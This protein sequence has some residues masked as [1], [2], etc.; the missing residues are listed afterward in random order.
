[1][2]QFLLLS[3]AIIANVL[4]NIGFK[5]SAIYEADPAK[6]WGYLAVGLVFGLINS[7]LFTESLKYFSLQVASTAFFALTI[8]GLFLVSHYWF[9][10]A[11]TWLRGVGGLVIVAGVILMSIEGGV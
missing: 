8:V 2:V 11:V 10:E 4:T 9:G 5:Y 3:G 6:K 1:M 7:V